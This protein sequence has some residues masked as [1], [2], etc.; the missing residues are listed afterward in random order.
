MC[1]E[2]CQKSDGEDLGIARVVLRDLLEHAFSLV[3]MDGEKLGLVFRS[4]EKA[5]RMVSGMVEFEIQEN[6]GVGY[7]PN[8]FEDLRPLTDE[9][10]K[11]DLEQTD[12]VFE[13]GD[14]LYSFDPSGDVQRKDDVVFALF[15]KNAP[16]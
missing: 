15:H 5:L 6:S 2:V 4:R 9:K 13:K 7:F 1:A 16:R 11:A 3:A 12:R 10:L 8:G 14:V